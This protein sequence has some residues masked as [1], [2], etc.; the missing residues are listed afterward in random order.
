MILD[1]KKVLPFTHQMVDN[2]DQ[3]FYNDDISI[4][5]GGNHGIRL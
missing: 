3:M 5:L 1:F 2:F 4:F